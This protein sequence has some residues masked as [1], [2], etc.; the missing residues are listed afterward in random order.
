MANERQWNAVPPVLLTAN[1]TTTGI[2]QVADTAGFYF[3]AQ[4]T[5]KNN[6]GLQ[7]T[8]YVKMVVSATT[9]YVGPTKGG[10][11]YNV[12]LSGFTVATGSFI[13]AAAQNK[14]TV[15]MEARLQATYETDPIDAWRVRPVDAYGN[16]YS[17]SNPLPVAFDGT[18]SIGDVHILGPSPTNNEL[19]V[20]SDGSINVIVESTPSPNS[21]VISTYNEVLSV[22]SGSTVQINSY[23]V[24]V[25]MQAVLQRCVVSGENIA[26]YDLLINSVKQDTLRTMFGGD[27][28]AVFE[29]T[30]GNDSGLLLPAGTVVSVQVYNYRPSTADFESRIQVLQLP[31]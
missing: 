21:T 15:P 4:A 10:Q 14:S 13:E 12:D 18:V 22:A 26:R 29:F 19:I 5:L 6:A 30:T 3:G 23:T 11:D 24:P 20:N 17:D 31:A 7:L 25:G 28:N 8:V 9:M 27:F 2:L 16:G 1:G